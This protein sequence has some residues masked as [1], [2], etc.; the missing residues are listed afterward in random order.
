MFFIQGFVYGMSKSLMTKVYYKLFTRQYQTHF[1][2][3]TGQNGKSCVKTY[4]LGCSWFGGIDNHKQYGLTTYRT[5][6]YFKEKINING[7]LQFD[8]T[9]L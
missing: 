3:I 7:Y 8:S 5:E 9:S 6:K 2:Y 1:G 4:T